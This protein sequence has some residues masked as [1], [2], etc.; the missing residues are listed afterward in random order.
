MVKTFVVSSFWH[1]LR[2][3]NRRTIRQINVDS[4]FCRSDLLIVGGSRLEPQIKCP[5]S[6][7]VWQNKDGGSQKVPH[8]NSRHDS[9]QGEQA[10]LQGGGIGFS[11]A[12]LGLS[13]IL[14]LTPGALPMQLFEMFD[15]KYMVQCSYKSHNSSKVSKKSVQLY[16]L[17]AFVLFL[18]AAIFRGLS[19]QLQTHGVNIKVSI[20]ACIASA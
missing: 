7:V 6:N 1:H 2:H 11:C 20:D 5:G 12:S 17:N 15:K 4:V 13:K 10:G 9:S 19:G 18:N 3:K 14:E 8:C 16:P